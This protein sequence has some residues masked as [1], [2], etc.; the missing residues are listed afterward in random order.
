MSNMLSVQSAYC[1]FMC[2][3]YIHVDPPISIIEFVWQVPGKH[4]GQGRDHTAMDPA[5]DCAKPKV[6][7]HLY[8]FLRM[9]S[10][11]S[12]YQRWLPPRFMKFGFLLYP[13]M[14]GDVFDEASLRFVKHISLAKVLR[15]NDGVLPVAPPVLSRA[16]QA[17]YTLQNPSKCINSCKYLQCFCLPC[18]FPPCPWKHSNAMAWWPVAMSLHWLCHFIE[19][20]GEIVNSPIS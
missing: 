7:F 9:V 16:F 12:F 2:I 18:S 1:I 14:Y 10:S 6:Q 3:M 20:G 17:L 19:K 4:Q 15:M 13:A 5:V 8:L 11:Q